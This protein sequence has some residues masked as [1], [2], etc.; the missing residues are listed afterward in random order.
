MAFTTTVSSTGGAKMKAVLAKAEQ[1]RRKQIKVGFFS[2]AKYEGRTNPFVVARRIEQLGDAH[3]P[4]RPA[5]V[6]EGAVRCE[7]RCHPGVRCAQRQHPGEAFLP[8]VHRHHG[9]GTAGRW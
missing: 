9:K 8:A 2:S 6:G 7:R 1:S 5:N 3:G 4:V